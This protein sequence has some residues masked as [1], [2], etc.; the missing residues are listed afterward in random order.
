MKQFIKR[1]WLGVPLAIIV[2]IIAVSMVAG[3]TLAQWMFNKTT[4]GHVSVSGSDV[5]LFS[6]AGC[7]TSIANNGALSAFILNRDLDSPVSNNVVIYLKNR[8]NTNLRPNISVAGLTTGM[9]LNETTSGVIGSVPVALMPIVFTPSGLANGTEVANPLS[10][11][12]A[13]IPAIVLDTI[14]ATLPQAGYFK[15]DNEICSYNGWTGTTLRNIKRG[16][17]GT[18]PVLHNQPLT[19]IWGTDGGNSVLAPNAVRTITLNISALPTI[20]LNA[21]SDFNITIHSDA[22]N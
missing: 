5:E 9:T 4:T 14:P 21:T 6:D 12:S 10:G 22:G 3:G 18:V 1:K 7:T 15:L 16:Q 19:F 11:D 20:A 17:M 8:G 13:D 2:A